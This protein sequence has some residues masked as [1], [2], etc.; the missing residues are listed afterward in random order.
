MALVKLGVGAEVDIATGDELRD[1]TASILGAVREDTEPRPIYMS[2]SNVDIGD[3][4]NGI[5]DLGAPPVGSLWQ[6]RLITLFGND[7]HTVVAGMTAAMYLGNPAS[8]SLAQLVLTGLAIPSATFI[9]DTCV[10][11]QPQAN[12]VVATSIAVPAGQQVGATVVIEEW[13]QRDVSRI[14]GRP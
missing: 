9:P 10:W 6:L 8:L 3:G 12:V 4:V 1:S 2:R 13:R 14:G 7:D 5:I 11:C